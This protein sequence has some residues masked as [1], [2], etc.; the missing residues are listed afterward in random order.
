MAKS[1]H[2]DGTYG[3]DTASKALSAVDEAIHLAESAP[4]PHPAEML[5]HVSATLS[6]RQQRQ[7]EELMQTQLD[8]LKGED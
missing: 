8:R 4:P 3:K 2:W 1:G 5:D 6:P 7:R